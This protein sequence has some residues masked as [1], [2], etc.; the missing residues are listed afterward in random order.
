MTKAAPIDAARLGLALNELRLPAIRPSGRRSPPGPTRRAGRRRASWPRSPSTRSP[1]ATGGGSS[2]ISARRACRR[3]RRSTT[4]TSR[5]C[6]WSARRRSWRLDRRRQ[7]A[8]QGRQP[9]RCSAGP[10][11]AR[12][13]WRPRSGWPWW[14][15]AGG[16]C[17]PAPPTWCRSL[18]NAR[19]DLQLEAAIAKLDKYHLL[20]L[21]DL[22][23]VS[24]DQAETQRAVRADQPTAT[25]AARCSSRPTSPSATGGGSSR[26]QAMTLGRRRSSGSPRHDLRD[27]CREL[28]PARGDGAQAWR[29]TP[30]LARDPRAGRLIVA[31]RH[32][33]L[34][35][36]SPWFDA[37][38]RARVEKS[39]R[40]SSR[41]L[42]RATARRAGQQR[43]AA[44]GAPPRAGAPGRGRAEHGEH[45][46]VDP[47]EHR[48]T[49]TTSWGERHDAHRRRAS[50][51]PLALLS[52]SD[53]HPACSD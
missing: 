14:R 33:W 27:E 10:A 16:C 40:P 52:R 32:P 25:S 48:G 29:R 12:R 53:N 13:T 46:L 42:P 8:R 4:S 18:Q 11:A 9:A 21:D 23:Y 44:A 26:I 1:S 49:G 30:A 22:A 28:P 51:M 47:L 39:G 31:W 19:R 5:R 38:R 43:R 45:P 41:P 50:R 24:K 36:D 37:A 7:L 20:I 3:A 34:V 6:R 17:S 35:G 2:G 15:T